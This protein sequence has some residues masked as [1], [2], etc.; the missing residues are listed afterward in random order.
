MDINQLINPP[1]N[2]PPSNNP[3]VFIGNQNQGFS[4]NNSPANMG[5]N[6]Y[7]PSDVTPSNKPV[8]PPRS[9]I[10]SINDIDY[11]P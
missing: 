1:N 7:V 4:A 6:F 9:S 3:N 11:Y 2:Y 8:N 10:N 5:P